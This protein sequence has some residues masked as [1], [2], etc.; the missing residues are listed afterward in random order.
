MEFT[1]SHRPRFDL[2]RSPRQADSRL[3]HIETG[4]GLPSRHC[5]V[6]DISDGGARLVVHAPETLPAEFVL[7]EGAVR[8]F[9][10]RR[11][12]IVWRAEAQVGVQ[13]VAEPEVPG[14]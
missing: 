14:R 4:D 8:A 13:F 1:T 3:A 2:C 6:C 12:R 7:V 11:C 5:M 9:S 10:R